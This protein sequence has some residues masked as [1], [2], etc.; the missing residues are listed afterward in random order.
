MEETLGASP[1]H[2]YALSAEEHR[3]LRGRPPEAALRWA[4]AAIGPGARLRSIR[5]LAGGASA[6]VHALGVE[7]RAGRLHR[8]VLRR[9]VRA[10]WLAEEPD[11]AAREA[12]AL[13]LLRASPIAAPRL[14]AVDPI[15]E[16]AGAPAVLMTR[17]PGRIEWAP[18]D[19]DAFLRRLIA[20]LPIIHAMS[21]PPGALIPPYRPYALEMRRPP[22]WAAQ[23][24]VWRRAIEV[25]DGPAPSDERRFIHRDYHPGNVLWS[26]GRVSGVID[27]VNAS[28]G[29]PEADV[30]HCRCNLADRFG[31]P[32]ADRFLA[33]YRSVAGR[34]RYHPYWDIAAAIGGLDESNDERPDPATERFLALAVAAL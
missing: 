28:L 7:D 16:S 3:L 18:P 20:P 13:D 11:L 6:A 23:P 4:A 26:R 9:F 2:G 29:A 31:Q 5:P 14:V 25:C 32:A 34:D 17:L 27:W 22:R 21:V 1:P 30:G 15:G 8:L 12:A 10:A 33:L 24:D 19:L